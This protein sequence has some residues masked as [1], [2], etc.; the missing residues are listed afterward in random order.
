M[1]F[2]I[3][4][5]IMFAGCNTIEFNGKAF[6]GL[7][8]NRSI[9]IDSISFHQRSTSDLKGVRDLTPNGTRGIVLP[10]DFHEKDCAN[11]QGILKVNL[12]EKRLSDFPEARNLHTNTL[13]R[14]TE[15]FYGFAFI[16]PD[17]FEN[18]SRVFLTEVLRKGEFEVMDSS[19]LKLN[20]TYSYE[21]NYLRK[22]R[23]WL[24]TLFVQISIYRTDS[25]EL[26]YLCDRPVVSQSVNGLL[27]H[28]IYKNGVQNF[29]SDLFLG[30]PEFEGEYRQYYPSLKSG[31]EFCMNEFF[32]NVNELP[33]K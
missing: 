17:S 15:D 29:F 4:L 9:T 23:A 21:L 7:E 1:K 2:L 27:R 5:L 10:I 31:V 30:F 13:F 16:V 22:G 12:C 8:N 32:K 28:T 18:R 6:Q 11:A 26:V 33:S 19:K 14:S 25:S 20:L 24:F 3:L